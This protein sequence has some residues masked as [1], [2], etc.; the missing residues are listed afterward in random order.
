MNENIEEVML[1]LL[2]K[3]AVYGLDEHEE[4]Q[5]AE[6]ESKLGGASQSQSFELTAATLSLAHLDMSEP[7]PANLQARIVADGNRYFDERSAADTPLIT[8]EAEPAKR[9][10]IFDWLGW[11]V[12]AAACV[13]LALNIYYTRERTAATIGQGKPTPT[14][15]EKLTPAQERQ[16]L[17]ET[18]PDL[19]RATWGPGKMADVKPAGD[20][21]WSDSKQAGYMRLSGLPKNDP[22]KETY[23]LWIIAE[24]Q[25]PKTPVD[26]GT[27]DIN[28]DGEVI[29]PIDAKVKALNPQVF[30]ITIERPGG[31]PVSKQEK[32]PALAKRET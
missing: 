2:C 20:V 25:D 18:A 10:S 6:I 9:G 21:V 4:K 8:R 27:F 26:G 23:Q 15:V 31:V 5:L 11:A 24:N 7:M 30:A 17:M 28:S 12:A 1:D 16:R 3:K 13:A 29:I 14:P 32:V 19:A 22:S